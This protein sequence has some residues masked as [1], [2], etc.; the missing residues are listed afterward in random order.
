MIPSQ[1]IVVGSRVRVS[2]HGA[3][4]VAMDNEDGTWNIN[5]DD[6][7]EG[8]FKESDLA[9]LLDQSLEELRLPAAPTSQEV[10]NGIRVIVGDPSKVPTP[11]GWTRFVCFSDTHG[12]HGS[13]PAAHMP[14]ADV[15]LHGG[16]FTNTGELDQIES[17]AAWLQAYPAKEKVVIAGNHETTFH[18][19]FYTTGG[20]S[21]FHDPPLDW[22]R[23]KGLLTRNG[24]CTYLEDA[25]TEA[26]GYLVYG[27]PWQPAFCDWAFNL[28]TES[29]LWRK[30]Q[31]IPQDVDILLTHG[32][33]RG[34]GDHTSQDRRMGCAEL[35]DAIKARGVPVN[36]CGHI[37]AG[38]G[39]AADESTLYINASTC[40]SAYSPC[41]PPIVFDAPPAALLRS[42]TCKRG[43]GTGG[44]RQE[45]AA[46][47][48][49][50]WV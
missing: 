45:V 15:L 31:E 32:P 36:V 10:P 39:W 42:A 44:A 29:D 7:G 18:E 5:F 9:L 41:N 3:G 49:D 47:S 35:R 30:W 14:S 8:N 13:I 16:D 25:S 12:L 40:N 1:V 38:Y 46:T 23:A 50:E 22:T 37:H 48:L 19:E 17:F 34:Y 26:L 21:R 24:C 11:E 28:A 2:S 20:G 6:D 33:P 27:S 43:G 4:M